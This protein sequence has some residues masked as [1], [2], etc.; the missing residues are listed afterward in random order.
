MNTEYEVRILNI[1]VLEITQK[2]NSLNAEKVFGALQRRYVYD[3]NTKVD[4]KWI[5]LRTNG[6]KSTLTIKDLTSK[7]ID[8]T[9]ELEIQDSN[10]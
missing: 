5:R 10:E 6:K 3:F 1:D 8:G 2:L 4:N 7:T 9:K